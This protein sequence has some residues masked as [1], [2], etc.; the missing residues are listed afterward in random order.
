MLWN[1]RLR[2]RMGGGLQVN[3]R[4]K[5]IPKPVYKG[6]NLPAFDTTSIKSNIQCSKVKKAVQIAQSFDMQWKWV[7]IAGRV[8]SN[9]R[10]HLSTRTR[11]ALRCGLF[12]MI[13]S[14]DVTSR[15]ISQQERT[16]FHNCICLLWVNGSA[17]DDSRQTRTLSVYG[18]IRFRVKRSSWDQTRIVVFSFPFSSFLSFCLSFFLFLPFSLLFFFL[19][20]LCLFVLE[21]Q[22]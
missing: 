3:T 22:K 7:T 18:S 1:V 2:V 16:Y 9:A 17:F 21:G 15:L 13:S 5:T 14:G 12:W 20:F 6:N 8:I 19:I 11:A 4:E 10:W